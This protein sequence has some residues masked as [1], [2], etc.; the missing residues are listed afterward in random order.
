ME[1][2]TLSAFRGGMVRGPFSY[3]CADLP[4]AIIETLVNGVRV[5]RATMPSSG[6]SNLAARSSQS[7]SQHIPRLRVRRISR[8]CARIAVT[9]WWAGEPSLATRRTG[10][11]V[12]TL[13]VAWHTASRAS[14]KPTM[15]KVRGVSKLAAACVQPARRRP[16]GRRR[17]GVP[18]RSACH[19]EVASTPRR[20]R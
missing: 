15:E 7:G 6:P 9:K 20:S 11:H 10:I 18:A 13:A 12:S 17:H 2:R 8:I 1:G 4:P 5:H 3:S 16:R 14:P 19:G